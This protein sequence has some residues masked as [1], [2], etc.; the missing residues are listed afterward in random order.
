MAV[1][2]PVLAN[3]AIRRVE[4]AWLTSIAAEW[5]YLVSLLVFAY[6][7]G[8]VLGVGLVSTLRTLPAALMAPMLSHLSDRYPRTQVLLASRVLRGLAIGIAALAVAADLPP[9]VPIAAAVVEGLVAPL[10]RATMLS[11]LPAIARS[12]GEL[13]ASNALTSVGEAAGV[14]LGPALGGLLLTIGGPALGIGIPAVAFLAAAAMVAGMRVA[15][16]VRVRSM[17]AGGPSFL[18]QTLAGFGALLRYRSAGTVVGLFVSQT[19]VRGI[20]TVLVVVAAVELLGLG[21]SGVG[22]LNSAIGAGGLI[23]AA[24]ALTLVVGR[25]LSL[26]FVFALALWG[27]PIALIGL[28]PHAAFA[29]VF[30]AVLGGA[31]AM[32]DVAGF[33]L[34]QRSVPN[35]VRGR[36]F[37]ALEALAALSIA[38]GSLIAPLLV[39]VAG[40]QGALIITGAIL[41]ILA[42]LFTPAVRRADAAAVVPHRQL[43]LLQ[44]IPM[45]APLSLTGL[46]H[47]AQSLV[48]M[49]SVAGDHLVR[50][51]DVGDA[52]YLIES[53]TADVIR[54]GERLA[55]VGPGDGF[56]EIALLRDVPRTASVIAT[57][58][59]TSYALPRAAFLAAVTGTP[60]STDVAGSLV[61]SRM[62]DLERT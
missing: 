51:G 25:Q 60:D 53:G 55:G 26:P 9:A 32:L 27:I 4:A 40:L 34:L 3:R 56:G 49:A 47:L 13:V 11:L 16:P 45:F 2:R 46:E 17:A 36:V 61:A 12:P 62:A 59:L 29:F 43:T 8:G 19:L 23:G 39:Q 10:H 31:N 57:D 20:L 24:V 48:P 6:T 14:L 15:A 28:L 50:Q 7:A 18:S 22:W 30:L 54:D 1:L 5:A 35:E 41:P 38:A 37:G 52:Y 44:G 42:A 21:D 33:T 58:A